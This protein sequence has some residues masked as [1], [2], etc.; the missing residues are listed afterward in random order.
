MNS[1]T[2]AAGPLTPA[3][4]FELLQAHQKTAALRAAIELDVFRASRAGS[5]RRRFDRPSRQGIRT[6]HSHPVR[7]LVVSGLLVKEDGIYKHTPSSAA[8]L[9]PTSPSCLAT[10]ARVP[11]AA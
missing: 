3:I 9:D 5:R 1:D 11:V 8:F 7:L 2:P 4:V 6:G 10:V